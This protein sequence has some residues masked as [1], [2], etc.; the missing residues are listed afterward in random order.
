MNKPDL[1][2][3]E[4]H[5]E[6]GKNWQSFS[7]TVDERSVKFAEEGVLKLLTRDELAGKSFLDIGCGSGI[8]S[9]AAS[10]LG[11]ARLTSVDI[12]PVCIATTK[13]LIQQH[14]GAGVAHDLREISVFDLSPQD[15]GTFD[16]VY[17]WGVLHHTGSMYE[18]I[19][20]AAAMT[21]AG[22]LFV[23]ALYRRTSAIMDKFWTA[24]KRWYTSASPTARKRADAT[25]KALMRLG[26]RATGRSYADYVKNYKGVRGADHDHDVS[27][28]MGGYPYEVISPDEVAQTMKNLGFQHVRSFVSS[29][30]GV[31]G[32]GCDE[33]TYRKM[34]G[35]P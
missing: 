13:A 20:R 25:F 7:G 14:G 35:A 2:R 8:H 19:S 27:D 31:F 32:S 12:D 28:W 21:S 33:F 18:A 34:P 9:L 16:I 6:F 10:R 30:I 24:E 15:L 3:L 1:K 26:F 5:Y 11:V 17:S 22:G 23:F 4:T 29:G